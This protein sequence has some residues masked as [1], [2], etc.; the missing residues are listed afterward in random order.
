MYYFRNIMNIL[1][2][3]A[4]VYNFIKIFIFYINMLVSQEIIH[5]VKVLVPD[6]CMPQF[7]SHSYFTCMVV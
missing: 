2:Y 7:S 3:K 4:I 5:L 1:F 6:F